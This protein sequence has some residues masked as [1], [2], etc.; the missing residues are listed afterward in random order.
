[1]RSIMMLI[2]KWCGTNLPSIINS[3]TSEGQSCATC[4]R[5]L[6]HCRAL[7]PSSVSFSTSS[8]S[9]CPGDT[10]TRPY[11]FSSPSHSEPF[12]GIGQHSSG[13]S[14][15]VSSHYPVKTY[16]LLELKTKQHQKDKKEKREAAR[17]LEHVLLSC[18]H[19]LL[20]SYTLRPRLPAAGG[21]ATTIT[22]LKSHAQSTKHS[23]WEHGFQIHGWQACTL[24]T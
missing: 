14:C 1:M 4:A 3:L 12:L 13:C 18:L 11:R 15:E 21:P 19:G 17:A 7:M 5:T 6:P 23:S 20:D 2:T 8:R 10:W 16:F 22:C 9:S 24:L